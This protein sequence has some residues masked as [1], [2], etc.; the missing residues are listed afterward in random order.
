MRAEQAGATQGYPMLALEKGGSANILAGRS[1]GCGEG[2]QCSPNAPCPPPSTCEHTWRVGPVSP[3]TW[4]GAEATSYT[5][6]RGDAGC[7][8]AG[9]LGCRPG[10]AAPQPPMGSLPAPTAPARRPSA[11]PTA[12]LSARTRL[13]FAAASPVS[14]AGAS[15][16]TPLSPRSRLK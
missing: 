3:S 10:V 16:L 6:L 14:H 9:G 4:S 11:R 2:G 5:Q 12:H 8:T 7:S 15:A 13:S 1:P